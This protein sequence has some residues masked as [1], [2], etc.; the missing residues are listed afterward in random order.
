MSGNFA[1]LPQS[2][3]RAA[4][5]KARRRSARSAEVLI[6][7]SF[8]DASNAAFHPTTPTCPSSNS[9]AMMRVPFATI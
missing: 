6:S 1:P 9:I 2:G 5:I 4:R 8:R 3:N 7:I